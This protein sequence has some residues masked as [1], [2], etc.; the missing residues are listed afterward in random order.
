[1]SNREDTF[2][3]S[4]VRSFIIS[5]KAI[6][7]SIVVREKRV[8]EKR[9]DCAC[10][11][12]AYQFDVVCRQGTLGTIEL[13]FPPRALLLIYKDDV[14]GTEAEIASLLGRIVVKCLCTR[15]T[16]RRCRGASLHTPTALGSAYAN[17]THARTHANASE[18]RVRAHVQE[19]GRAARPPWAEQTQTAAQRSS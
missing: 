4:F 14:A 17:N 1:M 5:V 10:V 7:V 2:V 11:P 12:D 9:R 3:R 8:Q 15:P 6:Y 13:A 19:G 16:R 18:C